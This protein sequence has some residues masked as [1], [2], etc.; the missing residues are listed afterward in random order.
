MELKFCPWLLY[1]IVNCLTRW[2][3]WT[4]GKDIGFGIFRK[5]SD[6]KQKAAEMEEVLESK[7]VNSHMIPE[8]GSFTCD[9]PGTC[10]AQLNSD[11]ETLASIFA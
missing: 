6:Q 1:L 3:F 7:R 11:F 5:T 9:E 2:N 4:E 10:E 8:N